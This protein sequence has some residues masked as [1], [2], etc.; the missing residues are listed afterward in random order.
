MTGDGKKVGAEIAEK[1]C[2]VFAENADNQRTLQ[3]VFFIRD[4]GFL[5]MS[6]KTPRVIRDGF[7]SIFTTSVVLV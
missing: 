7:L 4:S 5:T 1:R 6:N 2:R 3:A